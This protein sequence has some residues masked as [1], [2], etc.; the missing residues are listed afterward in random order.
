MHG[1]HTRCG[2]V[3]RSSL[4]LPRLQDCWI[5]G[6]FCQNESVHSFEL[7]SCMVVKQQAAPA[8]EE[9]LP[10][11]MKETHLAEWS[12]SRTTSRFTHSSYSNWMLPAW[13]LM[14]NWLFCNLQMKQQFEIWMF[15]TWKFEFE[16]LKFESFKFKSVKVWN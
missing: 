7:P 11:D 5:E 16:S 8:R 12:R 14:H 15:Q 6:Y 9:A 1:C 4:Q 3:W 10:L 2:S 13:L